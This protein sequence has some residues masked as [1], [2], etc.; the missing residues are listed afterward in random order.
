[1]IMVFLV[2]CS[3]AHKADGRDGCNQSKTSLSLTKSCK[4]AWVEAVQPEGTDAS[5][6][7]KLGRHDKQTAAEV[8][9]E[10]HLGSMFRGDAPRFGE[11]L[12]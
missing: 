9:K 10:T 6:N 7:A 4:I 12:W 5:V 1:M 8:H 11:S 3:G 2:N